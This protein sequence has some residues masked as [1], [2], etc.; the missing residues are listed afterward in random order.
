MSVNCFTRIPLRNEDIFLVVVS[1]TTSP[2]FILCP[3]AVARRL[4]VGQHMGDILLSIEAHYQCED[5]QHRGSTLLASPRP[6]LR[7]N[8]TG[9]KSYFRFHFKNNNNNL[10]IWFISAQPMEPMLP[11]FFLS[12]HRQNAGATIVTTFTMCDFFCVGT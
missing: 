7:E 9:D 11:C 3:D 10:M 1:I 6:E 5:V 4:I 8:L 2:L 12:N